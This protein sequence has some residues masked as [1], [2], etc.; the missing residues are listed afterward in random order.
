MKV[1]WA[2]FNL[3]LSVG[4]FSILILAIGWLDRDKNF[5]SKL[6]KMWA[7]WVIY[8]TG[9]KYDVTGLENLDPKKKYIFMSNHESAL[10]ILLGV[11]CLPYKIIFLAKKELFMIPVFGWAMQAAGMI[12]I[13]RQDPDRAKKSIDDAVNRLIYSSFS[14]FIY[15]EGTRSKTGDLL[16]FKKGGFILAIRSQ[17]PIVPITIIG[18]GDVLPKG[19]LTI[20]KG[21]I[22]VIISKPILTDNLETNNT[23][24]LVESCRNEIIENLAG[25]FEHKQEDYGLFL[26]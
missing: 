23:K 18:S 20:N 19:S 26:L 16:P 15:P 13:D 25:T 12:K 14:T 1:V 17:L 10:D 8:A 4:I 22:K 3:I 2:L 24:E 7:K 9:I 6:S 5:T 11:A 21:Q